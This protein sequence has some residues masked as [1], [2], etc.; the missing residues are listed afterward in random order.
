VIAFSTA[1]QAGLVETALT[2]MG[3]TDGL[4]PLVVLCGHGATTTANPHEA[5]LA[6][7]ACAGN[8]GGA[9]ARALATMAN[10]PEVRSIL[11]ERGMVIPAGTHVIA[12]EHDTT[13]DEVELFDLDAVPAALGPAV[14]RLR[15]DLARAGAALADE[16]AEDLG[17][18]RSDG[19]RSARRRARDWSETR[20]EWGLAGNADFI[21]APR[22]T[23]AGADLGRRAFLHSYDP[24]ADVDG[25]ALETILTAPM[26]VAHWI[27]MQYY[28]S[29]V[30]PEVL[31]AGDKAVHNPVGSIGVLAGSGGDLCLG[32]PWQS[33]GRGEEAYHEPLRL[34]TVVE[35]PVERVEAVIARNPIL[36]HLFDGSWVH[37]VIREPGLDE[38]RRRL[39]GGALAPIP[40]EEATCPSPA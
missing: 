6:C 29:T 20:P 34:L 37:L 39:P 26:V 1:E 19:A 14:E 11:A 7:G 24:E 33:V 16:R 8:R 18:A 12:A 13:T 35:A 36:Q 40:H 32:L 17:A 22:A 28:A 15:H 23:S 2:T 9:N 3:L 21:V 27:N 4:A 38:W 10:D 30:D 31:G 5:G 25:T